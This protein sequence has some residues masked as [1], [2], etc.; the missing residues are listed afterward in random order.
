MVGQADSHIPV[1]ASF[2]FSMFRCRDA[3]VMLV[4]HKSAPVALLAVVSRT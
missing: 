3:L 1:A 2:L 4:L